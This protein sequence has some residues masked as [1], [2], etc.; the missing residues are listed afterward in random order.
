MAQKTSSGKKLYSILK[1]AWECNEDLATIKIWSKALEAESEDPTDIAEKLG[2]LVELINDVK[3]D[4]KG[5]SISNT[6]KFLKPLGKIQVFIM[7]N[8]LISVNSWKSIKSSITEETLDL[9]DACGDLII[10][11]TK[12]VNEIS[13]EEL[14]EL[15]QQVRALI[16]EIFASDIEE[17][18]KSFLINELIKIEVAILN[19]KI[20]GSS[21][22]TK[23]SDETTGKIMKFSILTGLAKEHIGK[24]ISLLI[25]IDKANKGYE[26]GHKV[27]NGFTEVLHRLPP[28]HGG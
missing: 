3:N 14:G 12:G 21:G 9:I 20:R 5:L 13:L 17:N 11:Q 25:N 16:D 24:I 7:S 2:Q 6:N 26:V 22:L 15:H 1:Q 23:V 4:V 18:A 10:S 8:N 27:I 19:Y 28:G